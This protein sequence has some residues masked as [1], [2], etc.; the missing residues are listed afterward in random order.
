MGRLAEAS[1]PDNPINIM[2]AQIK[3]IMARSISTLDLGSFRR[4]QAVEVGEAL[5]AQWIKNGWAR[6]PLPV[7]EELEAAKKSVLEA[8]NEVHAVEVEIEKPHRRTR[9]HAT[10]TTAVPPAPAPV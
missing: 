8:A 6:A 2:P 5:A 7:D 10:A 3:V 1:A 9:K 4:G